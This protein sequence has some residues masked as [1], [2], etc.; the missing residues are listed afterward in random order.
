MS[1]YRTH[2]VMVPAHCRAGLLEYIEHGTPVGGFLTALLS[3]DLKETYARADDENRGAV[4]SYVQFLYSHAPSTCWG[5]PKRVED[6]IEQG[7]L[8]GKLGI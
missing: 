6:W 3:N 8:A 2:I 5:S 7:G 1:D 4:L